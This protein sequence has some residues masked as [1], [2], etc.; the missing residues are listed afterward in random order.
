[1]TF[2]FLSL[3][4]LAAIFFSQAR[5]NEV[6]FADFPFLIACEA[7]GIQYA[8]Y[9]SRIDRDGTAV[10]LTL[11]GQAGTITLDGTPKRVGG[12][13]IASS[14][15]GMTLEQLRAAGQAYYLLR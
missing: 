8:F 14:C 9:L 13:G 5:A 15:S 7:S 12:G 2:A 6:S 10:Y 3:F 4:Q 11:T 1:M